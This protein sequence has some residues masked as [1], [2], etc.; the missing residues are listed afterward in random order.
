MAKLW[1]KM[2]LNG[3]VSKSFDILLGRS[4]MLIEKLVL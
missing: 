3:A 4:I 1:R 2:G